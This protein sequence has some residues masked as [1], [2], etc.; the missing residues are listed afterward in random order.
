MREAGGA[1]AFPDA[2]E[3]GPLSAGLDLDMRSRVFA[4]ATEGILEELLAAQRSEG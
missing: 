1:V 2:G 3:G 4:G